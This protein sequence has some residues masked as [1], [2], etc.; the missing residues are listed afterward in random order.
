MTDSIDVGCR[1]PQPREYLGDGLYAEFDGYQLWLISS[2][3]KRD[4][5]RVAL[6]PATYRS[7]VAVAARIWGRRS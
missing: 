7:L 5:N 2:D 1:P 6:E 4:L 3:G